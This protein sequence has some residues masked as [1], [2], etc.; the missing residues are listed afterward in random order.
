MISAASPRGRTLFPSCSRGAGVVLPLSARAGRTIAPVTTSPDRRRL[1]KDD[2]LRHDD[3]DSR[4]TTPI[5]MT[6]PEWLAR[7]SESRQSEWED[8]L[9]IPF[10]PLTPRHAQ[11]RQAV[12]MVLGVFV[13]EGRLGE[14]LFA[15]FEMRLAR[16]A[17]EPAVLFVTTA[18]HTRLTEERLVGPADLVVEVVAYE[19]EHRD[20]VTKFDGHANAGIS[21]YWIGDPRPGRGT[22][23]GFALGASGYQPIPADSDGWIPWRVLPGFR[24]DPVRFGEGDP[25]L[26]ASLRS[27][28]PEWSGRPRQGRSG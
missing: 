12:A 16:S 27:L 9:A 2:V 4:V 6:Y 10:P 28:L 3:R 20:R 17:R 5:Q 18:D 26:L 13:E 19:S 24:F 25:D 8:G 22:L 21:E 15:P 23:A 7:A 14:M 1:G 11:A